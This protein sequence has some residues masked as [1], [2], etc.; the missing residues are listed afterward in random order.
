MPS[1]TVSNFFTIST[2]I[3]YMEKYLAEEENIHDALE[4]VAAHITLFVD[5]FIQLRGTFMN[6][7]YCLT[8]WRTCVEHGLDLDYIIKG[9]D[10]ELTLL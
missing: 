4:K 1:L 3:T 7:N 6:V 2:L 10:L 5:R 9:M 8:L